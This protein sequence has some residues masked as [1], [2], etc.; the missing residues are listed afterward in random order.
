MA[1]LCF[2]ATASTIM[3]DRA[4]E[5]TG[6]A[7]SGQRVAVARVLLLGPEAAFR[8]GS[9]RHCGCLMRPPTRGSGHGDSPSGLAST[10]RYPSGSRSQNS[11]CAGPPGPSGGLR[12]GGRTISASS[13]C[14]RPTAASKSSISNHS[15]TPFAVGARRGVA[16]FAAVM[17]DIEGMQLE[18]E[19]PVAKQPFVLIATVPALTAEKLLVEATAS[20]DIRHRDQ[21]LGT[22]HREV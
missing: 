17:L 18:H 19:R 15:A 21:R 1:P 22:H 6:S 10:T 16:D 7:Q 13:A 11:R 9:A 14:A 3:P 4:R 12:C 2:W 20:P 8:S 5:T